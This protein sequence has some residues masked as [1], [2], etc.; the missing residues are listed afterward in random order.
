MFI[1][2]Y[3]STVDVPPPRET[4]QEETRDTSL[5]N[6]SENYPDEDIPEEEDDEDMDEDDEDME[7]GDYKVNVLILSET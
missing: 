3:Q 4:T 2:W 5:D 1:C 6:D 7:E